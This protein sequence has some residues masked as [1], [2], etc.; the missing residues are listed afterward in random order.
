[1][2]TRTSESKQL[3]SGHSR[4]AV[5]LVGGVTKGEVMDRTSR[6]A[7]A[8]ILSIVVFLVWCALENQAMALQIE[9]EPS[10]D[11]LPGG[12]LFQKIVN[13]AGQVAIWLFAIGFVVGCGMWA[14]GGLSGN[15]QSSARGQK[16][17]FVSTGAA[18]L[19][20]GAAAILNIVYEA[21]GAIS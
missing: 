6:A 11:G 1:M 2:G 7:K 16:T 13:W 10:S 8:A 9:I 4:V 18:I 12:D 15:P 3:I 5:R 20:G 17:I 21:G 19:V 14:V